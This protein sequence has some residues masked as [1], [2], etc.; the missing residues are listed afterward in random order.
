MFTLAGASQEGRLLVIDYPALLS[1]TVTST[2]FTAISG[3][4]GGFCMHPATTYSTTETTLYLVSHLSSAG[5]TYKMSTIT[6]TSSAPV[7]TIG[8][9]N[10]RP[11]GGWSQVS[12]NIFPQQCLSSCPGTLMFADPGDQYNRGNVVFRNGFVWHVQTILASSAPVHTMVQWT[13]LNATTGL[14]VDGGRIEDATA[15]NANGGRWYGHPS[16][17]VN[18]NNDMVMGFA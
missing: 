18:S 13:K 12:G 14:V 1:G 10:T 5:A 2:L 17:A 11:G 3:A 16:V 7:L 9:T 6:G 15:T 4:N 8:G